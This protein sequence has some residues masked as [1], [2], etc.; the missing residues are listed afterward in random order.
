MIVSFELVRPV[1]RQIEELLATGGDVEG[2][3]SLALA[4]GSDIELP[5]DELNAAVRRS[6]LLLAAG[7][8]PTRE[9]ELDGRAVTALAADLDAPARRNE[10]A[11][12]L[13]GLRHPAAGLPLVEGALARLSADSDLAW[14]SFACAL[15]AHELGS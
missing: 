10:L 5:E 11:A 9:L 13:A 8:D 6:V 14:R 7:G 1:M 4:A 3:V 12:R 15:L 2:L